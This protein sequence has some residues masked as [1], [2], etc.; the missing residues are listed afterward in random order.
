M[1]KSYVLHSQKIR[2]KK[3]DNK[4]KKALKLRWIIFAILSIAYLFVYFHRLSL[5]VVADDLVRD[6]KTSAGTIGLLG[7]VYF[8]CYAIMQFPAGLLSDSI[9]P[10]KTV[11]FFLIIASIGSVIFGF[12]PNIHT[13]FV[14]RVLVGLGVSMVFIPTM[15]TMSQW[16]KTQEFAI[17]AGILNAMGGMGVLAG[18]WALA[19]MTIVFGW[20]LSFE[21]IGISTLLL[22][23]FVWFIVSDRPE[24]KGFPSIIDMETDEKGENSAQK[25]ISLMEGAKLV[26]SEK[27]FWAVAIWFFFDCGIFFGFGGLWAGP[28][29]MHA[30]GI[31]K[32]ETG[33]ILSMIAW[34]MIIGS[35]L[36]GFISDKVL[37]SRKK[38]FMICAGLLSLDIL[39]LYLFPPYFPIYLIYLIFFIFSVSSS[40]IVIIGF[41]TTK[42]LFPVKI[43]GTSI[44][45]V[46]FFPFL[47]GA[48]FMPF[49][50][51]ILDIF[52]KTDSGYSVK[53]YSY[54]ILI[55]LLS[56]VVVFLSTFFM[57]ETYKKTA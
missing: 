7:S 43:A 26:V 29:L 20:R 12:A 57:K 18:T 34:G 54:I 10:R 32:E 30:H 40:A 2:S 9:G 48:V 45:L 36:L 46:N 38:I 24:N 50:G 52:P 27:Y 28:F 17:M 55:L 39:A 14:G 21:I 16:F 1:K 11:T 37:K 15:K 53:G 22:A 8:Y 3:I 33:A 13:A 56:S 4:L 5:S 44:G 23:V 47:G 49:L 31:S 19:L 35:P 41:T 51:W 6:F 42:E 25:K